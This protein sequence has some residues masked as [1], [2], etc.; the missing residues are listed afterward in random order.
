MKRFIN[1]H[2][3]QISGVLSCPD[4]LVF[5]GYLRSIQYPDGLFRY[6]NYLR[7][8]LK[9]FLTTAKKNRDEIKAHA[10]NSAAA[11]NRPYEYLKSPKESKENRAREIAE[12]DG[13]KEGLICVFGCSELSPGF[14]IYKNRGKK[15]LE[16]VSRF[17]PCLHVYFYIMDR[18]FGFMY[19]RLQTW[20]PF[21][22]Q[23]GI[24]GHEYLARRMDKAGMSYVKEGNCFTY[25]EDIKKAQK[26]ADD[27]LKRKWPRVFNS[28]ARRTNPVISW[29]FS[30]RP[31]KYY[32]VVHQS[33]Y[34]T[35]VMFK[36]ASA[37]SEIYPELVRR[38]ISDFD[39]DSVMRFLGKKGVSQNFKG[40]LVG[41]RM[42]RSEG[43]CI[44]HHV[45]KNSLKMYD[46]AGSVL[47]VEMTINNP[48]MFSIYRKIEG[49]EESKKAP[50]RKGTAD[51]L[52]RMK[53]S[54]A[55]NERYLN[56]LS[57]Y[58]N[59]SPS[60]KIFDSVTKRKRKNDKSIR[61]IKPVDH[62]EVQFFRAILNK[63]HSS[64]YFRSKDI[65]DRLYDTK[66]CDEITKRKRTN[67][68]NRRLRLFRE[69]GLIAKI[70]NTHAYRL[71]DKGN[72]VFITAT[73]FRSENTCLLKLSA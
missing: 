52:R 12:R 48:T 28:M 22:I 47:R 57:V 45:R 4:R 31:G 38:A 54:L 24:N 50:M 32:W 36:S 8:L 70:P 37:L 23:I 19:I 29:P 56:A 42:R 58:G 25:I 59:T 27:L 7:I 21:K 71:T 14:D 63:T 41:R 39:S 5:R 67:Y 6:L 66:P 17:R 33:E 46:K 3:D 43:V 72:N 16:L 30:K 64:F 2:Q 68:M 9:D 62:E 11:E 73:E 26:M 69:H 53:I 65:Q 1:R 20:F 34:S 15:I 55:A 61:A 44:K 10:Q 51:F 49:S 40:E 35:N 18:E 60:Y 13:I